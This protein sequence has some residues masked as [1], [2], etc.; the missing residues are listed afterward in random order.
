MNI[1]EIYLN[2]K[3][4]IYVVY[5]KGIFSKKNNLEFKHLNIVK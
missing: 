4:C 5:K 3:L 1:S 2:T